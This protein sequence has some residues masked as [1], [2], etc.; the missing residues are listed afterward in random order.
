MPSDVTT[1]TLAR[2][3]VDG[4]GWSGCVIAS[5][6]ASITPG[7]ATSGLDTDAGVDDGLCALD[8]PDGSAPDSRSLCFAPSRHHRARALGRAFLNTAYH[9][10]QSYTEV[11]PFPEGGL[12]ASSAEIHQLN[13][14]AIA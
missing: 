2:S 5:I 13:S 14:K 12:R 7:A 9:L 1:D 6:S 4:A 10:G 8:A 3:A 11:T